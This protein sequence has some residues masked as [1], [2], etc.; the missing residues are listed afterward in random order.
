MLVTNKDIEEYRRP[1]LLAQ[2]SCRG[3]RQD[4]GERPGEFWR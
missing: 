4:V 1:M 2:R 3:L